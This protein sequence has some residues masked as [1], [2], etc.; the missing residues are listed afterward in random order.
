MEL[1]VSDSAIAGVKPKTNLL[2][3]RG[4]YADIRVPVLQLPAVFRTTCFKE[5]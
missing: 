2:A 1:R 5:R 4:L 3:V